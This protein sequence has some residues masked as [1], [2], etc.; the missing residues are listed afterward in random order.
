[1]YHVLVTR[2]VLALATLLAIACVLFA[3]LKSA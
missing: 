1:M 2:V 3:V